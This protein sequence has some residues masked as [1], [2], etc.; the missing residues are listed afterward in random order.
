MQ[1]LW[2]G[3]LLGLAGSM[4]CILMCGPLANGM[5][6]ASSQRK[7]FFLKNSLYQGGRIG[8]YLVIGLVFGLIG[9]LFSLIFYQQLLSVISGSFLLIWALLYALQRSG[10]N[11][12]VIRAWS[13]ATSG[14]FKRLR[15]HRTHLSVF[16]LGML[17]GFLP[18]GMVYMAATASL[19]NGNIGY[20]LAFML[21][22]GMGTL[23]AMTG[24][25]ASHN[26]VPIRLK[27]S[28]RK[29]SPLLLTAL[30]LLF[31]LRGLSLDI[32]YLSPKL[33]QNNGA[34]IHNCC[35]HDN[36]AKLNLRV[37]KNIITNLK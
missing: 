18:C 6:A 23:P 24:V 17:N 30:G 2:A 13:R 15:G 10:S 32:P 4:H 34:V 26:L 22:F 25:I 33:V 36:A 19:N 1:L 9:K 8:A 29:L 21:L 14:L 16:G 37:E 35:K 3:L 5:L 28:F 27:L 11:S 20:S 12:F 7:G 31:V